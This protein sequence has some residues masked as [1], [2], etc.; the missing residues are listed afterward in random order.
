MTSNFER[1]IKGELEKNLRGQESDRLIACPNCGTE[2]RIPGQV[3]MFGGE[4]DCPNNCGQ[5]FTFQSDAGDQFAS[6]I[7][8]FRK[9]L[10]RINRRGR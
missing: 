4:M 3:L 9:S 6:A 8:D 2:F 1:K 10:K 5:S 7:E